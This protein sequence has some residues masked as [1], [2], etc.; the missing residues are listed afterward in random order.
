MRNLLLLFLFFTLSCCKPDP[1]LISS[2]IETNVFGTIKDE[3]DEPIPNMIVR[4]GEYR[5]SRNSVFALSEDI[6]FVKWSD[7]AYTNSE[8]KYNFNF[9]TS[10][11]GNFYDL[12]IG[13]E[14]KASEPQVIFFEE[15][16]NITHEANDMTFMGKQFEY[17]SNYLIR[18]YPCRITFKV[19]NVETFPVRIIHQYTRGF[20]LKDLT[21]NGTSEQIIYI[22]RYNNEKVTLFRIKNGVGQHAIFEFPASNVKEVTYQTITVQEA[23]FIN[24]K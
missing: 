15:R 10:G 8:G 23:D 16:A 18:L 14:A 20:N 12:M 5:A 19:N 24:E 13:R 1:V 22:Q 17:N 2:G 4:V 3:H 9:K 21:A 7:S 11:K 6:D